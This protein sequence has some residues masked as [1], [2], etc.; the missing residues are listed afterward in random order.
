MA[1]KIKHQSKERKAKLLST[2][3]Q[4]ID[5]KTKEDYIRKVG[6]FKEEAIKNMSDTQLNELVEVG[7]GIKGFE[8]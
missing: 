7:I 4:K 1:Y 3:I 5:R 8:I 2:F 6:L